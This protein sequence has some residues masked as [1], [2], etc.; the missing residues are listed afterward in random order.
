MSINIYLTA[1][2]THIIQYQ[3][4]PLSNFTLN[5]MNIFERTH[6]FVPGQFIRHYTSNYYFVLINA[7]NEKHRRALDKN[8]IWIRFHSTS[9]EHIVTDK[10]T[11]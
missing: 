1:K 10:K 7:K 2:E 11:P 8:M 5:D 3:F 9:W 4:K 6:A